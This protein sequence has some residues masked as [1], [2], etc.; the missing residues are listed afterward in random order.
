MILQT[1]HELLDPFDAYARKLGY[2]LVKF[3]FTGS[4]SSNPSYSVHIYATGQIRI[5]DQNDILFYRNPT[6][7]YA[8][9][10]PIPLDWLTDEDLRKKIK[11]KNED[12]A[13]YPPD[14]FV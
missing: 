13:G 7:G 3:M 4:T 9:E 1:V 10:P 12:M 11:V 8:L 5:V 2:C 14:L 6:T